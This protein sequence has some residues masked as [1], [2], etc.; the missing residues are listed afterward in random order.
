MLPGMAGRP[1]TPFSND[2]FLTVLGIV[3][4]VGAIVFDQWAIKGALVLFALAL[5]VYA[6]RRHGSHPLIRYPV[7]LATITI[8]S[9]EPWNGIWA[10]FHKDYPAAEWLE[11]V[12]WPSFH[13]ALVISAALA[14]GWDWV[15][16][17]R[18]R[19]RFRFAWRI[20]LGEEIWISRDAALKVMRASDWGRAKEPAK[21]LFGA[22][23]FLGSDD[24][25]KESRLKLYL[26][27]TLDRFEESEAAYVRDRDGKKEYAESRLLLFLRRSMQ[28]ELEK[29]FGAL[30][31]VG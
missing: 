21:T 24:E 18:T 27:L 19:H 9:F 17:W 6:G 8:F 15:P 28:A 16:F 7:A 26:A 23:G 11:F 30:P 25:K 13:W 22:T 31:K 2:T 4:G 20:F 3:A 29:E 5:I 14:L 12:T 10:D 1:R